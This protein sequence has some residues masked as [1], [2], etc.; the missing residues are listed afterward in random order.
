MRERIGD[1]L[2]IGRRRR[3]ART[4]PGIADN[5]VQD[6]FL[7]R[8]P[9]APGALTP[10]PDELEALVALPLEAASKVLCDG[11]DAMGLRLAESE[12]LP[13]EVIRSRDFVPA[14]DGYYQK[15]FGSVKAAI[16]G[17]RAEAWV[18]E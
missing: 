17:A 9:V 8:S 7:A 12:S 2:Q 11:G 3:S 6:I 16:E 13:S 18:I 1:L 10:S 15:A 14:R 5:E 4:K